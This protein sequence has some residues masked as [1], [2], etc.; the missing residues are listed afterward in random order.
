[1]CTA[2]ENIM[3][4][5]GINNW[6][7]SVTK[8]FTVFSESR[9]VSFRGEFYNAFNHTQ[10]SG[11]NSSAIFNAQGQQINAAFGE[12]NAARLPRYVQISARFVF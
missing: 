5:S 10:F 7:I 6:D 12:A 11:W 3:N 1:M 9:T 8:R 2:G 4:G